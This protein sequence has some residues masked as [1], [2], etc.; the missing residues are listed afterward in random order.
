MKS[1]LNLLQSMTTPSTSRHVASRPRTL[2][3][4]NVVGSRRRRRRCGHVLTSSRQH[5]EHLPEIKI[6]LGKASEFTLLNFEI[7]FFLKTDKL[8]SAFK[9]R[10][11]SPGRRLLPIQIKCFKK[12]IYNQW[13]CSTYLC[14]QTRC[15]SCRRLV[16]L[17]GFAICR[18]SERRYFDVIR[19]HINAVQLPIDRN[20]IIENKWDIKC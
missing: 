13:H 8:K 14:P 20:A 7:T 9:L 17:S 1:D 2:L 12:S 4:I 3:C 6:R 19:R 16:D 10:L 15:Q 5:H 11:T 18:R